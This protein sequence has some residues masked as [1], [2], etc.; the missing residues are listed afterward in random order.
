MAKNQ[1]RSGNS[2]ITK[3]TWATVRMGHRE[4]NRRLGVPFEYVLSDID[5]DG[6]FDDYGNL[7]INLDFKIETKKESRERIT[8][9]K[10]IN[11]G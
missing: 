8:R 6:E 5:V 1:K 11:L 4:F 3:S 2:L 10:E 7:I 9:E